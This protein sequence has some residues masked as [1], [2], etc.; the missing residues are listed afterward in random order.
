MLAVWEICDITVTAPLKLSFGLGNQTVVRFDV[1]WILGLSWRAH[2]HEFVT[3]R[4]KFVIR[5]IQDVG[6]G[7]YT[8]RADG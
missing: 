1:S 6:H 2:S 7:W 8:I 4:Y 5:D 3:G